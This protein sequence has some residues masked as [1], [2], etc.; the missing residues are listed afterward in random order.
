MC[1]S[2]NL[3]ASTRSL[4]LTNLLRYFRVLN[5]PGDFWWKSSSFKFWILICW[6][7]SLNMV[8]LNACLS[9]PFIFLIHRNLGNNIFNEL[10]TAGLERL[11]HLKTF[12]NPNLREFPAPE[13]FPRIQTLVLS[14]AYHCCA[15]LPLISA[16]PHPKAPLHE[17]VIFPS[18][19]EFDMT[20]WNSSLTDIWPQLR[21]L[22]EAILCIKAFSKSL[23]ETEFVRTF[24]VRC[25][26]CVR[27]PRKFANDVGVT[28]YCISERLYFCMILHNLPWS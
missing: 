17:S 5:F 7:V 22:K 10:P 6:I 28:M 24:N 4:P 8:A 13:N 9:D 21:K 26:R 25:L 19:N 12:N 23:R 2:E 20:L 3:A 11:L 27:P 1:Y 14:Y 18:D 15:F 16:N